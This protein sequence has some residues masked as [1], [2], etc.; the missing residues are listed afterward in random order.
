MALKLGI[1]KEDKNVWERRVPLTPHAVEEFRKQGLE[2]WVE[3]F[4]RRAYIDEDYENA[5]ATMVDD[6]TPCDLVLGIKEMPA[7][8]F[9]EGGAYMFFSHTIKGQHHNMGMLR[10]LVEKKCTLLDYEQIKDDQGRRL[11]FFGRFAGLAGMIDTLWTLGQRLLAQGIDTPFK[12]I[13]QAHEFPSLQVARETISAVGRHIEE[14]GLPADLVPMVFGFTGYGNVSQGAQEIFDLLPYVEVQPKDLPEIVAAS[15]GVARKLIK[16]VYHEEHLAAPNDPAKR[17]DL[18][19]YYNHPERYHSIFE[20][21]L[22]LFTVLVNGIYWTEKYPRLATR[23]Q[24]A[25]LFAPAG[26][27]KLRVVGDVSCDVDGSLACTVMETEPGHPVYVYDPLT[28][29]AP[30]GFKGPGIAVMAVSN[31]PCE[32]PM[33]ASAFFSSVL[34]KYIEP[35]AQMRMDEPFSQC[36]LPTELKRSVILWRGEFTPAFSYMRDFLA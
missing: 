26:K 25:A 32:L 11:V 7:S 5:G 29:N 6:V 10:T 17:F 14:Q 18:L 21:H 22:P 33:E 35:L 34:H 1:R 24:L 15:T 23:D 28:A 27:A 8:K 12:E 2:I 20:P 4:P 31:L 36:R 9:R 3:R 19:E 16:V 13:T 30:M